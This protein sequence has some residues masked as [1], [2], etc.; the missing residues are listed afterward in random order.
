MI[1]N[2]A[3]NTFRTA[4]LIYRSKTNLMHLQS[5]KQ[6]SLTVFILLWFCGNSWSRVHGVGLTD[7]IFGKLCLMCTTVWVVIKWFLDKFQQPT[8]H[9]LLYLLPK[10][11]GTGEWF[12]SNRREWFVYVVC[13]VSLMTNYIK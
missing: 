2:P 11:L 4:F 9:L 13:H 6:C 10:Q 12:F 8:L 5:W 3:T 7:I 1:L